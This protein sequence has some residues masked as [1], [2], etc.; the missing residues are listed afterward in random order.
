M[1]VASAILVPSQMLFFQRHSQRQLGFRLHRWGM[2]RGLVPCRDLWTTRVRYSTIF[3]F[4][5]MSLH[6]ASTAG[7]GIL[8][9]LA[10][11]AAFFLLYRIIASFASSPISLGIALL[12]LVFVAHF[13]EDGNLCEAGRYYLSQARI[14]SP[15][16]GLKTD[17]HASVLLC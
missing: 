9:A 10:L 8:E 6:P 7:I 12:S 1:A 5:G 17:Q 3:E 16:D 14:T 13:S 11:S 4:T 15:G 2:T